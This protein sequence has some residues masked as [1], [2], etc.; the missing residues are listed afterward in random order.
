VPPPV[1]PGPE[2][3]GQFSWGDPARVRRIL[4]GAGFR[5]VALAPLDIRFTLGAEAADLAMFVGPGARLLHGLPDTTREAARA[6]FEAFF[7][8]HRGPEG[9]NLAGGLWLVSALN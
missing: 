7:K 5:E 3:P 1:P 8:T 9:V 6:A 4:G 2:E